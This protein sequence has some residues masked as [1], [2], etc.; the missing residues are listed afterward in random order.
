[1]RTI[2]ARLSSNLGVVAARMGRF[3]QSREAFQ[4]ALALFDELGKPQEVALQHGNLGSVCRD[5]GE[6]RQAIDSYHRAE[7]MLIELSGDGG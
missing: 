4:Q 7:E 3:P 1:M 2:K 5:T 6:Y